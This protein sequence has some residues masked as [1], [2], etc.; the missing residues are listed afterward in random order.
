MQALSDAFF[1]GETLTYVIAALVFF[2]GAH[3]LQSTFGP[4]FGRKI[5]QPKGLATGRLGIVK[6]AALDGQRQLVAI[7]CDESVHLVE[8]G[9]PNDLVVETYFSGAGGGFEDIEETAPG[10]DALEAVRFRRLRSYIQPA[11]R[12]FVGPGLVP[13]AVVSGIA[14][15][16]AGLICGLFRMSLEAADRFR[17]SLPGVWQGEPLLG[18][19]LLIMGAA[20]AGALSAWL[21]RR[22]SE[23]AAGSGIPHVEAVLNGELPPAPLILLP[24]KFFGGL[25][26][27]GSGFALGREGPCVQMGATLA[28]LLGKFLGRDPADCLSLLAAGAGAGLAAAFNAPF[29]GAVFVLEELTRKFDTR[30]AI[31]ALGASGSAIVVARLFTGPAPDF[32]VTNV[33]YPVLGDNLW[34]LALGAAAGLLGIV[35]NHVL[36]GALALADRLARWPVEIRAALVGAAV[37]ALAWFAPDLAGGGDALTQSALDGKAVLV[38]LPF[39]YVLRLF[40][41]AASYAVGTPGGVFAPLLVLGAQMGFIFGGLVDLSLAG[42]GTHATAFALVGMAALFAAVVRA[43]LTGMILVTEMTD[44]SRLLLPMLAACF[45]AMAVATILREPPLYDSLKERTLEQARKKA[46]LLSRKS[47]SEPV[48]IKVR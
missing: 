25:L 31:A 21:V 35:Y 43:P 40:L 41:G 1:Q 27:I 44:N 11:S 32:A 4:L 37:G 3:I 15:A 48:R 29:A 38:L 47:A 39:I 9:G 10:E 14:G 22:F 26:A 12:I 23:N 18:A 45:S 6:S 30:N 24:V 20:A 46:E 8:I 13:L 34:C 42:S 33:A 28:N 2:A 5:P 36:L 16:G 17:L 19:S 7:W